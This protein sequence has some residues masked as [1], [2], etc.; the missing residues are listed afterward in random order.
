MDEERIVFD[1]REEADLAKEE[2]LKIQEIM[3][4]ISAPNKESTLSYENDLREKQDKIKQFQTA[5]KEKYIEKIEKYLADFDKKFRGENFF[6]SG[7]TREDAGNE[8]ALKYVKTLPVDSYENLD[9]ARELLI[10]YLPEV[11]IT[12][13]QATLANEYF[14]RCEAFLNTVDGVQFNTR[15]EANYGR[16]EYREITSIMEGVIAPTS[17]SLLPYEKDLLDKKSKLQEYKTPIKEKY[18][19]KTRENQPNSF[20]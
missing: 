6:S 1:T 11:G 13:E 14:N 7:M 19:S 17:E 4:T 15:E 12:I 2:L 8:K 9:K 20:W 5:V 10:A 18:I 16:Q 3:K